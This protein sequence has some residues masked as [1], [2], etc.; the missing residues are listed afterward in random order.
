MV[1]T[2]K[3]A[4]DKYVD[5]HDRADNYD[6]YNQAADKRQDEETD[7]FESWFDNEGNSK[8]YFIQF[9]LEDPALIFEDSTIKKE[10]D[11]WNNNP[12]WDD[13]D[14]TK[15]IKWDDDYIYEKLKN[16]WYEGFKSWAYSYWLDE[17]K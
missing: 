12:G 16:E 8:Y 9:V 10:F 5:G 7:K 1:K 17:V 2:I 15:F 3:E 13:S 6:R 14:I 11:E 4:Y